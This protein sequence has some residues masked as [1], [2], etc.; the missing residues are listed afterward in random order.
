[1]KIKK[2]ILSNKT[3]KKAWVWGAINYLG[4]ENLYLHEENCDTFIYINVVKETMLEM[5]NFSG[6]ENVI[7]LMDNA[8]Y[9]WA[10]KI[11]QF[12]QENSIKVID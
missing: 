6:E 10:N 4:K 5:K 7:K 1:M 11:L 8:R 3:K 2:K 9:H 12:Y